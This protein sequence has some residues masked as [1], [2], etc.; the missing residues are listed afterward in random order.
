LYPRA[1]AEKIKMETYFPMNMT[2][3]HFINASE[4][5]I[6]LTVVIAKGFAIL[7]PWVAMS[8]ATFYWLF[9]TSGQRRSLMIA[10]ISL[11]SGLAANFLFAT[12]TYA[13][14]PFELGVGQI[15]LIHAAETSF[16]SDHATFLWALGFGLL[17]TRQLRV[18]GIVISMLGLATAWARIYV[19]VHFPLD[20]AASFLISV[21]SAVLA[22]AL[23]GKFDSFLFQP[24][25]QINSH[26]V[27]VIRHSFTK[28]RDE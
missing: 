12:L 10:G 23:A 17:V 25:E 24:L 27:W 11:S 7:S 2:L 15:L 21:L 18:L 3:F 9:G 4:T 13:P 22:R 6:A 26:I 16:P 20:M 1:F 5:P 14:R 8:L 28:N 19:G